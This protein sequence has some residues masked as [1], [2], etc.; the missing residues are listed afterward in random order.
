MSDITLAINPNVITSNITIDQTTIQVTPFAAELS[1]YAAGSPRPGGANTQVQFNDGNAF[2]GSA[3]FTFN[4]SSN[5]VTMGNTLTVAGNTTLNGNALFNTTTT[6]NTTLTVVGNL[7]TTGTTT[8]QQVK[9]K[10]TANGTGSTGTINY[11]LLTQAIILKT[12]NASANFTLNFRG[13]STTTL[14]TMLSSNQSITCTF[15]NTNGTTGYY[16][17]N[18]QIDGSNITPLW[19]GFGAPTIGT[20]SGKDAY[21]FN[22]IK[23]AANTYTVLASVIGYT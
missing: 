14:D 6:A 3:A 15:I 1:I 2:G 17:N 9:E 10:V 12:A 18:I 19:A 11:D 13:N 21:T 20:V 8:V 5:A 16:A 23:T 4:K 7:S 22:I